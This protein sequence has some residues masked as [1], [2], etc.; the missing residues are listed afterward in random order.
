M[1]KEKTGT[2][3][4][5]F[6]SRIE[7]LKHWGISADP[8]TRTRILRTKIWLE[9]S[10]ELLLRHYR[11]WKDYNESVVLTDAGWNVV[12]WIDNWT[13]TLLHIAWDF[14]YNNKWNIKRIKWNWKK[15]DRI[16]VTSRI[17]R[18]RDIYNLI[19]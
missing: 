12:I 11:F 3:L 9:N 1:N 7:T 19:W 16:W 6:L 18:L 15:F 4:N 10:I 14:D 8:Q 17:E 13:K 2:E 5:Y